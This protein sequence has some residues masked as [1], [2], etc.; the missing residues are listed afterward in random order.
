[1]HHGKRHERRLPTFG[2]SAK[3]ITQDAGRDLSSSCES[4]GVAQPK[5]RF[6]ASDGNAGLPREEA[7][8][9]GARP[10]LKSHASPKPSLSW[11]GDALTEKTGGATMAVF[12]IAK[13]SGGLRRASH[14]HRAQAR[15]SLYRRIGKQPFR[16]HEPIVVAQSLVEKP[17]QLLGVDLAARGVEAPDG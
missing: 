11:S 13:L 8:S 17:L 9:V 2:A 3:Q 14:G 4:S 7:K 5:V 16:C 1:L 15:S 6:I 10:N 12:P